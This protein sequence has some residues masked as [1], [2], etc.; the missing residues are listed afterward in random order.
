MPAGDR[1]IARIAEGILDQ[2]LGLPAEKPEP[3]PVAPKRALW[4]R[5]EGSYLGDWAGLATVRVEAD[6]LV[7]DHN[8][9]TMPLEALA[10]DLYMHRT[11]NEQ[12]EPETR[13]IGF[14]AEPD[15]PVQYVRVRGATARRIDLAGL[16][17]PDPAALARWAGVCDWDGL[18][19]A[20]LRAE[21]GRLF[22]RS[23]NRGDKEVEA[24]P[25]GER[26]F[27]TPFGTF[28]VEEGDDGAPRLR[29]ASTFVYRRVGDAPT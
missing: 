28:E 29:V 16:P 13:A 15:G 23:R 8:G 24:R 19:R 10:E 11:T 4:P 27:A 18:D 25:V 26:R 3:Q 20:T 17:S 12:G 7:L 2:L 22:A 5:Y 6:R 9:E 14:V 1:P 21:G